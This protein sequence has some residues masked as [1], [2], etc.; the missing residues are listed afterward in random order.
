MNMAPSV[1]YF[2]AVLMTSVMTVMSLPVGIAQAGMIST[3]QVMA[4]TDGDE[5]TALSTRDRVQA[6]LAKTDIRQE[7]MVLGVDPAE[8]EARVAA[9]TDDEI[10]RLAGQL[11]QLPAGE[12]IG[13]GG[14]LIILF[15]VF[16]VAVMLDAL[17]MMNIFP[18]VCGPGECL[19][20]RADV[21][22]QEQPAA[23]IEPSAGP[24]SRDF[25]YQE[26]QAQ[27][28]QAH[29]YRQNPY[30]SGTFS[31]RQQ[32]SYQTESYYDPTA[33]PPTR[34]YYEERFGTR[35]HLR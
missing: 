11:D 16:G 8:A 26:Q 32:P 15:V 34:D 31:Q 3:K 29:A 14:A 2:I 35:R 1:R 28:Q 24:A 19:S 13:V 5:P 23:Y 18:F 20:Q 21:I 10:D 17:G 7:M 27:Q 12:G 6:I 33:Q 30:R 22:Y 25:L 4:T 9:L